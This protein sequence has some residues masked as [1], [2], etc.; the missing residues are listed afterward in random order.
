MECTGRSRPVIAIE[1]LP[2]MAKSSWK[3]L[4]IGG[5]GVAVI[6]VGALLWYARD[7]PR[8]A[9][10]G[11]KPGGP[12]G[13]GPPAVAVEAAKVRVGAITRDI[14]AIG[15]MRSNESVVLRPE[16]A[17]RIS[18]IHFDEGATVAKGDD[19]ISLDAS[20]YEAELQQAE[21]SREL[22]RRNY[23][24]ATELLQKKAGT[25]RARDEAL[26]RM[27]V[28]EATVALARARLA[29]LTIKAP[30]AGIVGLRQVSI[31]DYVK[32][33]QDMVNLESIDPIKVD[34]RVPEIFLPAV[35]EGQTLRL[36]IDAFPGRTFEGVVYAVDPRLDPVGRS[37]AVRARIPNSDGTL[38][39]GLFARVRLIVEERDDAIIIPEQAVVPKGERLLVYRI[40]DGKAKETEVSLG[41]RH[42][43]EVEVTKGLGPDDM[44]VTAGQIKL[45]DG[46]P[47]RVVASSGEA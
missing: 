16:V 7:M 47:V 10:S 28:D 43:G 24:R 30:F 19:L 36:T 44:V 17:G 9:D 41:Q 32:E 39:P 8:A 45:R 22:S 25:V 5:V 18:E 34:F 33:G 40:V 31:G 29:K 20:V 1:I 42:G 14:A 13:G 35:A 4:A 37:V 26:E 27:S 6:I 3:K 11:A 12:P 38:R 15:N 23:E 2:A 21:A 46:A